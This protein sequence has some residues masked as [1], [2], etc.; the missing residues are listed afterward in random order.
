MHVTD[1]MRINNNSKQYSFWFYLVGMDF[2]VTRT[3]AFQ[4]PSEQKKTFLVKK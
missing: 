1:W 3:E 2:V 4:I